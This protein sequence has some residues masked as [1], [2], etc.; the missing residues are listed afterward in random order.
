MVSDESG[1]DFVQCAQI[2]DNNLPSSLEH[3]SP[4]Q[5]SHGES[6][7]TSDDE[8]GLDDADAVHYLED[9]DHEGSFGDSEQVAV[10]SD[11]YSW[12]INHARGDHKFKG[13]LG[14][15]YRLEY[16]LTLDK[17]R[18][19]L[20]RQEI[21]LL[22]ARRLLTCSRDGIHSTLEAEKPDQEPPLM[23]TSTSTP[24]IST[25]LSSSAVRFN[26]SHT[27]RAGSSTT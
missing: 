4:N 15:F 21:R 2:D 22:M 1:D 14:S 17:R 13:A 23:K 27:R 7:E 6:Y 19:L 9:D 12:K 8:D 20:P 3:P 10:A 11:Q 24:S 5:D 18:I 16:I 25:L 26:L